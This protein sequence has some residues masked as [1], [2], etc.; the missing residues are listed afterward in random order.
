[1]KNILD[2][3]PEIGSLTR[4]AEAA[5][6]GNPEAEPTLALHNM[7]EAFLYARK[8]C[9]GMLTED[10]IYSACYDALCKAAKNFKAGQIRFLGYSKPYLR[11]A[12]SQ[13]WKTKDT[14]PNKK[15]VRARQGEPT[16]LTEEIESE[17]IAE[18]ADGITG[19]FR[20]E[21]FVDV[22]PIVQPE[23]EVIQSREEWRLIEPLIQSTLTDKE[24]T[25]IA[26]RY[27]SALSFERI[28]ALLKISRQDIQLTHAG[29]LKK[30]RR[31]V[32]KKLHC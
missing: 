26:L 22:F 24:Q 14:V 13:V 29:A 8:C 27:K 5:L 12:L 28:G 21:R 20:K 9:R 11:G 17:D 18:E 25:V 31:A 10:E 30:L 2:G 23:L 16:R 6:A 7:R 4:E 32:K 19:I 3:L 1:M 15:N